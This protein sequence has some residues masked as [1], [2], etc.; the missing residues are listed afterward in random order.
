MAAVINRYRNSNRFSD[1]LRGIN[2]PQNEIARLR[3]DGFTSMESL[4]KNYTYNTNAFKVH[5]NSL[6]KTF[7]SHQTTPVYYNPILI[8]RLL[9]VLYHFDQAVNT[10]HQVPDIGQMSLALANELSSK[11]ADSLITEDDEDELEIKVPKLDGSVNWR[12]FKDKLILK[13]ATTKGARNIPL[14][15]VID[16][17]TRAVTTARSSLVVNNE[18]DVHDAEFIKT[19]ATHFGPHFKEDNKRVLLLLKRLL[20]NTPAYNHISVFCDTFNGR[21]AFKALKNYYEGEDYRERNI[22]T[23]FQRLNSTFYR[24]D[25][26]RFTFEKYVS[27]HMECHRL[28][29]EAEYNNG[30]GMDSATKIQHIKN[31]IKAEAGLEHALTTARTNRLAQGDFHSFVTFLSAEVELKNER[32]QQLNTRVQN[33]R[34]VSHNSDNYNN[35]NNRNRKNNRSGNNKGNN[36]SLGPMLSAFVDGKK[37]E[38]KIY[39]KN[40]FSNLTKNQ[41]SKVIELYRKRKEAGKNSSNSIS[42]VQSMTDTISAAVIAGV[43]AASSTNNDNDDLPTTVSPGNNIDHETQSHTT[44]TS[45]QSGSIGEF[46]AKRRK[47]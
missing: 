41:R 34:G 10:F 7:G 31:G 4:V 46:M 29:H 11:Y 15:Y 17:T 28:L 12:S 26:K 8:N 5:L 44:R 38:G 21:K 39:P 19:H 1:M 32:K 3:T 33:I 20:L 13:L 40:E 30:L 25:T 2:C 14:D 37:V 47:T 16:E 36:A 6:N 43:R 18:I 42:D 27:I 22:S 24:G 45:A 9:G 23:A 35:R